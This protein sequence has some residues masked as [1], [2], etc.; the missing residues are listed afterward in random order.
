MKLFSTLVCLAPLLLGLTVLTARAADGDLQLEAQWILGS[1]DTAAKGK[2][3]APEIEN[4]LK[5]LPLK[6][7]HYSVISTQ[8][9]TVARDGAKTVSLGTDCEITVKNLGAERVELTLAGRG[10]ITQ[11]LRKGQTLVTGGNEDNSIVVLR[12]AD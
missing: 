11:S 9:F 12:Q 8:A 10:K 2:P 5:R 4:K 3:V 6:W 7:Q 1:N